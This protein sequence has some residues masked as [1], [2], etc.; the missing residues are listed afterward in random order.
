MSSIYCKVK[1]RRGW[2]PRPMGTGGSSRQLP[3]RKC[4]S[5]GFHLVRPNLGGMEA[6]NLVADIA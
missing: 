3:H 4:G 6:K 5:C 2:L 1:T